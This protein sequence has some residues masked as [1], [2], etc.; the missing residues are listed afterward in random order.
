[1]NLTNI[2]VGFTEHTQTVFRASYTV[3]GYY[4][5]V[6]IVLCNS[7]VL[8]PI[9]A[10]IVLHTVFTYG[11]SIVLDFFA[12]QKLNKFCTNTMIITCILGGMALS[13]NVM[14]F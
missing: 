2:G 14:C 5:V 6:K 11:S 1:M 10:H 8:L 13:H 4:G 3:Y 7:Y 12:E 9:L